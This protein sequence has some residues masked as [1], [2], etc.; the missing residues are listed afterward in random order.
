VREPFGR[1][2]SISILGINILAASL[3][4]FQLHSNLSALTTHFIASI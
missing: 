3:V 2:F 4:A 1:S